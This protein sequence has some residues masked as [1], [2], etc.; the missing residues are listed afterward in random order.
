MKQIEKEAAAFRWIV[1]NGR[2]G[3]DRRLAATITL[4]LYP[5][6]DHLGQL[7]D[8]ILRRIEEGEEG[9]V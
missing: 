1:E 3:I 6:P 9:I 7:L 8:A 2:Y 5:A 4:D